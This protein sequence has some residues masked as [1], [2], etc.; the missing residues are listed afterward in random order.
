M[1]W[2]ADWTQADCPHDEKCSNGESCDW[3][4]DMY[5]RDFQPADGDWDDED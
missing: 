1:D 4:E 5:D 3:Y 2:W